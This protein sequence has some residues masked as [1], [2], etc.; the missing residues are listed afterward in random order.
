MT[1]RAP[2]PGRAALGRAQQKAD[3]D[4][5]IRA[6]AL[7]RMAEVLG[8]ELPPES[9]FHARNDVAAAAS[10]VARELGFTFDF[11]NADPVNRP[12][13]EVL[14]VL[15]RDAGIRLRKVLLR[16]RWERA[17]HG[18]LVAQLR[19]GLRPIALTRKGAKYIAHDVVNG[20]QVVVDSDLA[21]RIA[22]HA[23]CLYRPLPRHSLRIRDLLAF[24]SFATARDYALLALMTVVWALAGLL[25]PV[26]A[27]KIFDGVVPDRDVAL[28]IQFTLVLL[29]LAFASAMFDLSRKLV[30]LRLETRMGVSIQSAVWDRLLSLPAP[31][32][33]RFSA[34]ELAMRA[35]AIDEVRR[36]LTAV[37]ASAIA[38][39]V[40]ALVTLGL[41]FWYSASLALWASLLGAIAALVSVVAGL[42]KVRLQ[43]RAVD[44]QAR[45][46]GLVLQMLQGIAKIRVAGAEN[47][48][49]AVWASSFAAQKHFA[50]RA[51]K[52]DARLKSFNALFSIVATVVLFWLFL[53][54]VGRAGGLSL[55]DFVA[56]QY[57]FATF[58]G[59][60]VQVS[61]SAV[62]A[63]AVVPLL[64]NARPILEAVPEP[65]GK[66]T[67]PA[68]AGGAVDVS[69]VSFRYEGATK[70]V[71]DDVSLE[72]GA[73][74]FVALVG[75]SG[76]GKS[77]LFRMLLGFES[78]ESGAIYF[79]GRNLASLDRHKVRRSIG[80][81]LQNGRIM[82]GDIFTNIVGS[83]PLTHDDAWDLARM[84]GLAD[85]IRRMPMGMYT[86]L[87]EGATTLS[88]GQRQR[89]LIARAL[90]LRPALLLFDE[91]TSAL[92]NRTQE[93][94]HD[95]LAQL[96]VTRIVIAHRLSTIRSA[97]RVY[98]MEGGRIVE[99]GTTESLLRS[100]GAF[101]RLAQ[102]QL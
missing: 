33:R 34:G 24:G 80:V 56:F 65:A 58:I 60:I 68:I 85:D 89:L 12:V 45:L 37:V 91:A 20:A 94:V 69:H 93:A 38:G 62:Q 50:A 71:L 55:G 57:A 52:V 44:L 5:G 26:I 42:A 7:H 84:A 75:P 30:Y 72:A 102:R 2:Q 39:G 63:I 8:D 35:N 32:F 87:P 18:P 70:L 43:T 54:I 47:R 4:T 41:L 28:L 48:A 53:G 77:T 74:E 96:D 78:P 27:G 49:F 36:I 100:G 40:F 95:S 98:V 64:S 15:D 22:P 19:D 61:L 51:A 46:A 11:D 16:D 59:T 23:W 90:S 10:I 3:A 14:A 86:M 83:S 101:S 76:A 9:A 92:D 79:D 67:T 13:G 6:A 73:R 1:A 21:K 31:F 17:D 99:S 88:G 97:D 25:P 82:A 81:V 29:A 66:G